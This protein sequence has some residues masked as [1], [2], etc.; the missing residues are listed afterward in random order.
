MASEFGPDCVKPSVFVGTAIDREIA[1][2]GILSMKPLKSPART[3][4]GIE[5]GVARSPLSAD[6]RRELSEQNS[7]IVRKVLAVDRKR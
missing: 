1:D 5:Q 3:T 7:Q 4:A 2:P 6:L